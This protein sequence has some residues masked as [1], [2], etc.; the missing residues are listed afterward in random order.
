MDE[1][2]DNNF[3]NEDNFIYDEIVRRR[4]TACRTNWR[5]RATALTQ[6]DVALAASIQA[7]LSFCYSLMYLVIFQ[8]YLLNQWIQ[9]HNNEPNT[10]LFHRILKG[11]WFYHGLFTFCCYKVDA[12]IDE[13]TSIIYIRQHQLFPIEDTPV[14]NRSIDEISESTAKEL[15]RF[16]KEQLWVLLLH[17]RIPERVMTG[18][19]H[20]FSGEEIL[21]VSLARIATG[22]PWIRLIKGYFGGE[23]R[24]WSYAFKWFV[25]HLFTLFFNKISG[26]SIEMWLPEMQ[27][28]KQLIVD[29]LRKPA[30]FRELQ[31]IMI[32]VKET[33]RSITW[34]M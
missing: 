33:L 18:Y 20:V 32:L 4:Q 23:P 31:F 17:W 3:I 12:L 10:P 28:F 25:N 1:D 34:L 29:R 8:L 14:R 5:F 26:H 24:R 19:Q 11:I 13:E 2:D 15:T 16:N 6:R 22:D 27:H 21:L 9:L 30:H 7:S